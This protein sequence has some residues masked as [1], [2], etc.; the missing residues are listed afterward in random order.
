MPKSSVGIYISSKYVDIAQ[1][2]GSASSPRL[3]NFLRQDI[4]TK[5]EDEKQE[6]NNQ[7][8]ELYDTSGTVLA[9]KEGLS[10]IG[11]KSHDVNT[12]LSS[13]DVMIRY[14]DMP[15][16]P[17]SEQQTAVKF[18]AK[19]YIPFKLEEV[20]SDFRILPSQKDKKT[21][22]VFFI[23]ATKDR[24]DSHL[25]IFSKASTRPVNIDIVPFALL[26]MLLISKKVLPKENIAI[27]YFDSDKDTVSVHMMEA[28]MPF[29][30]R[31]IKIGTDDNDA[32]S[33]KLA[34]ELRVS[35]DYFH[36]QRP[37]TEIHKIAICGHSELPRVDS[38][39]SEELKVVVERIEGMPNVKN[40]DQAPPSALVATGA[41]LLGLGRSAYSINL[42]PF[43]VDVRKRVF[44]TRLI[45]QAIVAAAVLI[46]TYILSSISLQR[47]SSGLRAVRQRGDKLP[48]VTQGLPLKSLERMKEQRTESIKF[49]QLMLNNRISLAAKLARVSAKLVDGVWISSLDIRNGFIKKSDYYP[50]G[51]YDEFSISGKC[52]LEDPSKESARVNEFY[53]SLNEDKSF[54]D[55]FETIELGSI[56]KVSSGDYQITSFKIKAYSGSAP[57]QAQARRGIRRR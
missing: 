28:G 27:L 4:T 53:R 37:H 38:Y 39:L 9:I 24:L 42:S 15:P 12:V 45:T 56:E 8:K 11:S 29:L 1:V 6:Q 35:I 43:A 26:R 50:T 19:K 14:F 3:V 23:A 57:Q 7:V 51:Q 31:D 48:A 13:G 20:V 36:R 10:K 55:G 46:I 49:L 21:I 17:R 52:F 5:A 41:A 18:E 33:E 16:L 54:S 25:D 32:L 22:D 40:S 2:D 34:S 30:S 47:A 44:A